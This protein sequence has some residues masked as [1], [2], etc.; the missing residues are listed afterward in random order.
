V[1]GWEKVE[2][3]RWWQ[4][5]KKVESNIAFRVPEEWR[6]RKREGRVLEDRELATSEVAVV[7]LL[8]FHFPFFDTA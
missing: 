6:R 8:S 4:E 2:E 7:Y 1:E 3:A 5:V